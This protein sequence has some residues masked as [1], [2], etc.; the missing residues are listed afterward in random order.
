MVGAMEKTF[1]F[2]L[3]ATDSAV[4][5]RL[6]AL[7]TGPGDLDRRYTQ[8]EDFFLVL[9]RP[10]V[11]EPFEIHH[12]VSDPRPSAAYLR[13][14][15]RVL[16]AWTDQ[17]PGVFHG[18]SWYFDPKD[19]F[20]PLFVQVLASKGAHYL[21]LMRPDLTFRG[22]HGEILDRGGNNVT[23][24]YSTRHLFLDAEILPLQS[25]DFTSGEKSLT[26]R[27]L[28]PLTWIGEDGRGYFVTGRW[29]DHEITRI[30][31]KAALPAG[32]RTFPHY[33]LR[34]RFQTLSARCVTPTPDGRKR[35]AALLEASWPLVSPWADR[36]QTVLKD[37][38]YREDH[39]LISELRDSWG[40]RLSSRWGRYRL[41]PY[42]NE[43]DQKE[44][45]Y[46]G[47]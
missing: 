28:F 19:I 8:E 44:Y 37:D 27:R 5:D 36:I 25:W 4:T 9:D 41:E 21:F 42:L 43:N 13:A 23:P 6:K 17:V 14:L 2:L 29:L 12:A 34:C 38:P 47:E 1:D 15:Q 31:S 32:A 18:L 3:G 26:L 20:H 10:V 35:A 46:H 30:L 40:D 22:R 45:R 16:E 24:R 33:P 7:G 39:P 11:V